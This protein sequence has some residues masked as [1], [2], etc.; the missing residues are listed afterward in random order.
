MKQTIIAGLIGFAL[1]LLAPQ[2][3]QAQGM[4][5]V[6][7]NLNQTAAGSLAV[8]SDSWL[9]V[10]FITGTN[11]SGY[12]LNS[13][14]LGMA[15]SSGNPS[16]FMAMIYTKPPPGVTP[17]SSI[18]TLNGSLNPVAG[19]IFTYTAPSNFILSRNTYYCIV[20]TAGTAIANGAYDWSYVNAN[21][22]NPI[23][24][25]NVLGGVL[26]SSD[27]SSWNASSGGYA[28][29]AITVTDAP[30]PGVLGLFG[31]GGLAFLWHRRRATAVL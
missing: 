3:V 5:T 30:E 11:S 4:M 2:I 25:W 17:G 7:S 10:E 19:G 22:Y 12:V 16:G 24:G 13:I 29:Y 31:L 20:L 14:Q 15:S 21:S 28:Q 6:L 1:A 23:G 26:L 18:G 8:G 9:A 27:G